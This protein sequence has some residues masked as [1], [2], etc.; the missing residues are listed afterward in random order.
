MGAPFFAMAGDHTIALVMLY[1]GVSLGVSATVLYLR[2]GRV[3]LEQLS[4]S[5]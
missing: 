5:T 1:V 3:D 4:S 2:N